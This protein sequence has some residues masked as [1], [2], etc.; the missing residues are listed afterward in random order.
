MSDEEY[1][2]VDRQDLQDEIINIL[3]NY[4]LNENK[5]YEKALK[6]LKHVEWKK[7]ETEDE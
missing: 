5:G 7:E 4:I 3:F 2:Q 1:K 6:H